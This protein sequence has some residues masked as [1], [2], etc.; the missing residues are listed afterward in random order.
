MPDLVLSTPDVERVL[1]IFKTSKS[2]GPADIHPAVF[3]PIESS[4]IPQLVTIFNVSLNTGRIPEDLKHVAIV[5]IF[6]GGNQS[7]PSNYRLI[8]LTS[9]VAKLPERILREYICAHLEVLK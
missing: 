2:T 3:K 6:K 9:I 1:K 7:D 8:S 5:P 4:V